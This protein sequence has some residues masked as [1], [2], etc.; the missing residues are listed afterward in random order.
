MLDYLKPTA[1]VGTF[2]YSLLGVAFMVFT[3]W[4]IDRLTPGD[5]WKELIE[6]RNQAVATVAAGLFIAMAIIIAAAIVG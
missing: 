4:L 2:V 5:L 3:F 6:H 1:L